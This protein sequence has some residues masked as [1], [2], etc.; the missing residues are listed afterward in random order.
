[1]DHLVARKIREY[2]EGKLI[3]DHDQFQRI[4]MQCD[5]LM[6]MYAKHD[7]RLDTHECKLTVLQAYQDTHKVRSTTAS[8]KPE[9]FK[10]KSKVTILA[11]L[12]QMHKYLTARQVPSAEW[13]VIASTY[14]ETN[15]AQHW[16]VLAMELRTDKKD[17]LL[18][19]NFQDAL[20]TAYGSVNQEMVAR[21]KLRTLK[22]RGSVDE[23]ANEFQHM[24]SQITKSPIS[25]GDKVERFLSGL[26]EDVRS[27]VLV[28]PRGDGGPWE[29]IKRLINYVVTIDVTYTQ[30][31]KGRDD[32]KSHSDAAVAKGVGNIDVGTH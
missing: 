32:V 12:A 31:A 15:V 20:I 23:Y 11:W 3:D 4:E 25:R 13:V 2:C 1:M 18:W 28:D 16:D 26:K 6:A 29:D 17:P 22:Q 24:C 9:K 21:N 27:K 5:Q 7:G 19:D 8:A 10:D 14:L 30:A